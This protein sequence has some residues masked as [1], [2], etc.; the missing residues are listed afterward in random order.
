MLQ[1]TPQIAMILDADLPHSQTDPV[2]MPFAF[3]GQEVMSFSPQEYDAFRK[4]E[5][6]SYT[7]ME[8]RCVCAY[9]KW[10]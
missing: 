8:F 2:L 10:V 6:C 4:E 3:E 9:V 7:S 1:C 5:I